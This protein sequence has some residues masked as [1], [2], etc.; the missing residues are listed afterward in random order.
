MEQYN[1]AA[2]LHHKNIKP[3][4]LL[5]KKNLFENSQL[6]DRIGYTHIA[7]QKKYRIDIVQ[8]IENRLSKL[9][10]YWYKEVKN[11]LEKEGIA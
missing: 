7:G 10:P 9:F 5:W 3:T 4:L 2:L 6:A 8:E 11:A 1:L